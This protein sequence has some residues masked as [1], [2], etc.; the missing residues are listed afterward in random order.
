MEKTYG[1]GK[2]SGKKKI[3]METSVKRNRQTWGETGKEAWVLLIC[4][5]CSIIAVTC[6]IFAYTRGFVHSDLAAKVLF[7]H[8]Q[9][10]KHQYFPDGFCYSTGVFILGI[11]N[12]IYFFMIFMEDWVLCRQAAQFVQTLLL[13]GSVY[14]FFTTIFGKKK[15]SIGFAAG[16][17]LLVLP[18]SEVVYDLYYYQAAYTK[19]VICLLLLFT[20]A[21][22]IMTEQSRRK[23]QIW[24]WMF[25][26]LTVCNN[27]GIRNIILIEA[28]WIL[29]VLLMSFDVKSR[30]FQIEPKEKTIISWSCI[31]TAAGLIFY[32]L[33]ELYTGWENQFEA[34]AFVKLETM[35]AQIAG[36]ITAAFEI[37]GAGEQTALFS[38][39][40]IALPFR[41]LY[42]L[43]SVVIV[44]I[45]WLIC[46]KRVHNQ[47]WKWF[48]GY[49]WLSNLFLAYFFF[50]TSTGLSPM[51]MLSAYINN[52]IVLAG[53][54][55]YIWDHYFWKK[56]ICMIC[57]ACILL[58]HSVYI[59][60]CSETV[61]EKEAL[62][63]ELIQYLE[64]NDLDFGYAGFWN[65]SK[66]ML[67]TSGKIT[68]LSYTGEPNTPWY[69]L[70][71]REWYDPGYHKGKT[72]LLLEENEQVADRYYQNAERVEQVGDYMVLVF[73]QNLTDDPYLMYGILQEGRTQK[74]DTKDLYTMNK[75]WWNGDQICLEEGGMQY[76]PYLELESGTY[77]VCVKGADLQQTVFEISTGAD[78]QRKAVKLIKQ[79]EDQV[80]YQ[81]SLDDFT[82][83]TEFIAVN[84]GKDQAVIEQISL[85]YKKKHA[86][87]MVFYPFQLGHMGEASYD[88]GS[89][90]VEKGGMQY[91]PYADLQ[92][93]T[94]SVTIYGDNLDLAEV[95]VTAD[96]GETVIDTGQIC[97]KE[98][99]V[100][101]QFYLP[102]ATKDVEC[103]TINNQKE[104]I[105]VS[106]VCIQKLG[107]KLN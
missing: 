51:H 31:A 58:F 44:P 79:T 75:A 40:G 32:K 38:L 78:H 2:W 73:G 93:G 99:F 71:S 36:L 24:L 18:L 95:K 35:V 49:C 45:A 66:Y 76:G 53:T 13:F 60:Q 26:L 94:Y 41:F 83:E 96:Q 43:V 61:A 86:E 100:Q 90:R 4:A 56:T 107:E 15:G 22:K 5:A 14:C 80:V 17:I 55:I 54:V 1:T 62:D 70:T 16:V 84:M 6:Y 68:I 28:P 3:R 103:L 98:H 88:H 42:M 47:I 101:Y 20:V 27:L 34:V 97:K 25:V 67:L 39:T 37:Y 59:T 65:A 33:A 11:E 46:W 74:I 8:E 23:E 92:E 50:A 63:Q 64:E 106:R 102:H 72:F 105:T 91:G 104:P 89:I 81:F 85:Y 69:W 87:S 12:L 82:T 52:T 29:T 10:A 19:N 77:E 9:H 21:G 7:A 57:A 48:I 30:R